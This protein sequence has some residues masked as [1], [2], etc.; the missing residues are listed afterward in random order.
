MLMPLRLG[1]LLAALAPPLCWA[2]GGAAPAREPLCR[3]CRARLRFLDPEPV[4]LAGV[5]L[6]APVAYDGPARELVRGLKYRGAAGLADAL[7]SQIAATAPA[8]LLPR[9]A[10]E[11]CPHATDRGSSAKDIAIRPPAADACSA[12][13]VLVPV[14]T[15]RSRARRR[16][17]DQADLLAV[18]LARRT[19]LPVA[20]CLI[21]VRADAPQVGRGR[22][23]RLAALAGAFALRPGVEAPST[24]A[25]RRR[26]RHH[27]RHARRLRRGPARRRLRRGRGARLRAH[28]RSLIAYETGGFGTLASRGSR[29]YH[30]YTASRTH[31]ANPGGLAC[32]SR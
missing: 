20:R 24:V 25:A 19:G 17:Y 16:G 29:E 7:A 32:A 4:T 10:R 11:A 14:P 21:R 31:V 23:A 3:D 8:T 26:R 1:P 30:R 5:P 18:S 12:G 2:C 22:A 9:S 27:R 6:W 28:A 13:P 15:A